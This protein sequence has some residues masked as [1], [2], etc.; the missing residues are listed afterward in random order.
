M[1]YLSNK[2]QSNEGNY[3]TLKF[4]RKSIEALVDSGAIVSIINE[5]TAHDLNLTIERPSYREKI[6]LFSANG[7][8]MA[9]SGIADMRLYFAGLVIL[10]KVRVCSNLQH[11]ILLGLDFLKANSVILDYKS[12]ILSL[13]NDLVRIPLHS[14]SET[15][16]CVTVARKCCI[17]AYAEFD[18]PVRTPTPLYGTG[19]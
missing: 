12:G 16:N 18:I 17:P 19:T 11:S 3:I 2:I 4:G 13:N 1:H 5:K 7:T 14:K 15:L 10:Q 6:A 8:K 9:V